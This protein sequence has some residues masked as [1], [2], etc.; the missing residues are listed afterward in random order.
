MLP[1]LSAKG[2]KFLGQ[3]YLT[4]STGVPT[5]SG[6][7]TDTF[8]RDFQ[9]SCCSP[10]RILAMCSDSTS[11][12]MCPTMRSSSGCTA[13][14]PWISC[15]AKLPNVSQTPFLQRSYVI[16]YVETGYKVSFCVGGKIITCQSVDVRLAPSRLS[17]CRSGGSCSFHSP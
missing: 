4:W 11:M 13:G 17:S 14:L 15:R 9:P 16:Q 7:G 6:F 8:F 12:A 10:C 5:L 2:G 1:L 3:S